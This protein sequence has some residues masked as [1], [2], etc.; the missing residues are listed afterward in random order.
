MTDFPETRSTLLF[1]VKSPENREAW[2]EFVDLYHPAIY[3]MARRRGLQ[4]SDAQDLVQ[5]VLMRISRAIGDWEPQPGTRFRHWLRKITSNAVFTAL[6]RKPRDAARGGSEAVDRLAEHPQAVEEDAELEKEFKRERYLRAAALV[7][8]DVNAET[9]R[10]FELT[11][12]E[13][14]SCEET[15]ELIGKSIGTVYAA[16]SRIIKRLR[17]EVER[18]ESYES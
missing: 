8:S 17:L 11:V 18:M 2:E 1:D 4:D 14:K 6:N 5:N 13:G 15:A 10:A 16:R 3:R 9:W 12:I 7:K